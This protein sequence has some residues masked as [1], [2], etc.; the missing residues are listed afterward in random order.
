MKLQHLLLLLLPLLYHCNL[1]AQK[2]AIIIVKPGSTIKES[3]PITDL[4]EYPQFMHGTVFFRDGNSSGAAMN[5]NRFLDQMLFITAKGDT[6]ILAN[7]KNIKFINISNDT[8]FYDLGY[9]KLVNSTASVKLGMKQM[10]KIIDKEK[11]GAYGMSSSTTAVDSYNS[12]YDGIQIYNLTVMENLVLAKKVQYYIG[13]IYNHFVSVSK[14]NL[15]N[16][17]PKHEQ[18]VVRYLKENTVAFDN[19]ADLEKLVQFLEQ[20]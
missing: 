6:I 10:L 2:N 8:F 20:F 18:A 4:Y 12:F 14:K 5:Y 16:L 3:V 19:K 11:M 15:I 7:E 13:D 17:F 1:Y 9:I